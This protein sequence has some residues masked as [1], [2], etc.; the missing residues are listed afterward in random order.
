[1]ARIKKRK[2]VFYIYGVNGVLLLLWQVSGLSR[3]LGAV[4]TVFAPLPMSAMA[5]LIA[6]LVSLLTEI[7]SNAAVIN[8]VTPIIIAMVTSSSRLSSSNSRRLVVVVTSVVA[9]QA[10]AHI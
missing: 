7:T 8:V 9:N 4:L 2:N 10:I 5:L 3:Y 6:L 1:M